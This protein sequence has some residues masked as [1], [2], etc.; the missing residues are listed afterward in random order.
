MYEAKPPVTLAVQ[1]RKTQ[2]IP[3]IS[4]LREPLPMLL[5]FLILFFNI[6]RELLCVQVGYPFFKIQDQLKFESGT[7]FN[8]TSKVE[9]KSNTIYREAFKKIIKYDKQFFP[10]HIAHLQFSNVCV[11][12]TNVFLLRIIY[13][14]LFVQS[15]GTLEKNG[16][17]S[18]SIWEFISIKKRK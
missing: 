14:L 2:E 3:C 6:H 8:W 9:N 17:T 18:L 5:M 4:A 7:T 11:V 12:F 16:T 13:A 10:T 15:P 1:R